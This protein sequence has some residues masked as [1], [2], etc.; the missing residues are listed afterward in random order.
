MK[1]KVKNGANLLLRVRG[2]TKSREKNE[3]DLLL[4]VG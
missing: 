3:A 1:T 4:K 2:D